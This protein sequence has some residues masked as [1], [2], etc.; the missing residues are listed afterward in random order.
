MNLQQFLRALRARFG[1]FMLVLGATMLAAAVASL[2]L[3]KTYKATVT[4]LM[5]ARNEQS[6]SGAQRPLILP[7]ERLAFLETQKDILTSKKVARKVVQDLKLAEEPAVRMILGDEPAGAAPIEDRAVDAVLKKLKVETSQ[8]NVIRVSYASPDAAAAAQIANAFAG[9]YIDTLLQLHVEP[10]REATAWFEEQLKRLRASLEE[11]QARL[12][13]NY[14]QREI[15]AA[16][17]RL[18]V[19]NSRLQA[20]SDETVRAQERSFQWDSREQ[21]AR[22]AVRRGASPER[23]PDVLDNSFIQR[24][25]G[26]LLLGEARLKQLATQ[27][28]QNHPHYQRQVSENQ[29]LREKLDAEMAK[30]VASVGSSARQSRDRE[31]ALAQATEA[32]RKRMLGLKQGRNELTVLRRNVESAE[33]AYD[34]ALQ[35][36]VASQVDSRVNQTS[37]TVLS[38]AVVPGRPASPRMDLNLALAAAVGVML[39]IGI[40]LLLEMTDR[41]VRSQDDLENAWDVPLLGELKPWKP[42]RRLLGQSTK[43]PRALPNPG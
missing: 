32:Q 37:V 28:G 4:L 42:A 23:L 24:L 1:V 10:A 20:L 18:D 2:M 14:Q 13:E 8:S 12:T 15:V 7:L 40:V 9:A 22:N 16:D 38:P 5:D 6:L 19:E 3:A 27:Y 26:D 34:T 39:G 21:Q 41:R 11:A 17:E 29:S 36:S 30:V 33:R 35:R 31:A 43:E 25:K